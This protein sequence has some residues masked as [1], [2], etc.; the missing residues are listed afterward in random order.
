MRRAVRDAEGRFVLDGLEAGEWDVRAELLDG[1]TSEKVSVTLPS[2]GTPLE[3]LWIRA[4]TLAGVVLDPDGRPVAGARVT[5]PTGSFGRTDELDTTT[6]GQGRF[7]LARVPPGPRT[8]LASA[9][10]WPRSPGLS[11]ELAPAERREGLVL[12][13]RSGASLSLLVL[14]RDGKPEAGRAVRVFGGPLGEPVVTDAA[15]RCELELL[16]A[17]SY[18][19]STV[20][21]E[22]ELWAADLDPRLTRPDREELLVRH[23]RVEL[24]EGAHEE[25]VLGGPPAARIPVG[26]TILRAG[27]TVEGMKVE[28]G[29]ARAFSDAAGRFA[30]ASERAG[31]LWLTVVDPSGTRVPFRRDVPESGDEGLELGSGTVAGRVLTPEGE[32]LPK[33]RVWMVPEPSAPRFDEAVAAYGKT[34]ERGAFRFAGVPAGKYRLGA[35]GPAFHEG[36]Y[37]STSTTLELAEDALAERDLVLPRAGSLDVTVRD[38]AGR[39][40]PGAWVVCFDADGERETRR[41]PRDAVVHLGGLV[42][43]ERRL[44]ARNEG[45]AAALSAPIRVA[46]G[47][48]TT[49]EI[50]LAPAPLLTVTVAAAAGPP[51]PCRV[52]V[53]DEAGRVLDD[54]WLNSE[55]FPVSR[56]EVRLAPDSYLVEARAEDGRQ[57]RAEIRLGT[58]PEVTLK[59]RLEE[60]GP[61][62]PDSDRR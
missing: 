41:A 7:T 28:L 59:L 56:L 1:Q 52:R 32:G 27:R 13:L 19:F 55:S 62:Q 11:V 44:L 50:H 18:S 49:A 24:K 61:A 6:D 47:E 58:E 22:E 25:V 45:E 8:L 5:C 14:D 40:C 51:P 17:G 26:G 3:L 2:D 30:L 43:G 60:A 46:P 23:S 10:G 39:L 36:P 4:S 57:A 31:E 38:A 33:L 48:R 16:P 35:D 15:G 9:P 21:T 20:V 12:R 37:A 53:L 54:L 42:P 29:T 34:D